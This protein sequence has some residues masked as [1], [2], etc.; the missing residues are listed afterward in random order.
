MQSKLLPK[1]YPKVLLIG[2]L[3][4]FTSFVGSTPTTNCEQKFTFF[5]KLQY[6]DVFWIGEDL[7]GECGESNL[8]QV[9]FG[10]GKSSLKKMPLSQFERWEWI[11]S[12]KKAMRTEVFHTQEMDKEQVI[13]NED[14]GIKLRTPK[15]NNRLENDFTEKFAKNCARQWNERM[16]IDGIVEPI[17]WDMELD[18]VYYHPD[19]LYFNYKIEKVFIFPESDHLLIMTKQPM[20]CGMW[21]STP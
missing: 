5:F 14:M 3:I 15:E 2:M 19:G 7:F 11:E 10:E 21:A 13:D 17:A 12:V 20:R 4:G 8:I 9:F 18:L 1:K 16:K 6:D